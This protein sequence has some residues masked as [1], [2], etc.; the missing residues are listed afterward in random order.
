VRIPAALILGLLSLPATAQTI[1]LGG[2]TVTH[3][4]TALNN[5]GLVFTESAPNAWPAPYA[6]DVL[7]ISWD[8]SGQNMPDYTA[9]LDSGRHI[10]IIG[11]SGLA[12]YAAGFN[13]H[14]PNAYTGW[15]QSSGCANDWT[16]STPHPATQYLPATWEFADQANSYHMM[17]FNDLQDPA[18]VLLGH[19]CEGVP[20]HVAAIRTFANNGLLMYMGFDVGNYGAEPALSAFLTPLIQGF[21][22]AQTPCDDADADGI[23][24]AVDSCPGFDDLVD[25]DGDLIPDGCD[26]CPL[27]P[28]DDI[29]GDGV[30]GDLDP[31]P[32]DNPDD[33]DGDGVCDS[34]DIC[35]GDDTLDSDDDGYPDD[36]DNCPT[37][38]Q[39]FQRDDDGDGHGGQCDCDDADPEV[40]SDAFEVCDGRDQNCDDLIDNDPIDGVVFY[41]DADGDGE[42]TGDLTVTGCDD[43]APAGYVGNARDCD[44]TSAEISTAAPEVCDGLDNNCD[45]AA[46]NGITCEDVAEGHEGDGT[47]TAMVGCTCQTGRPPST[48]V[49]LL[50]LV[51]LRRRSTTPRQRFP[52]VH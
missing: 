33:S 13:T 20:N 36:C 4:R 6:A 3:P 39:Q 10:L 5:L 44:D 37:I 45:G 47:S 18:T 48:W 24:D 23:C 35:A 40:N 49:L 43:A 30:C 16:A 41:R 9:H 21:M 51:T 52:T 19:T 22:D 17:H 25:A 42:G 46:D 15:H 26:T 32:I 29:D 27:D 28:D 34:V 14:L 12:D 1:D 50:A 38:A 31:C 11:G 2:N 7:I 8:G